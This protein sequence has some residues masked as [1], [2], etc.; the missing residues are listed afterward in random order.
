ML[1]TRANEIAE[2]ATAW[3]LTGFADVMRCEV[4]SYADRS[5][6]RLLMGAE[7]ISLEVLTDHQQAL[8]RAETLRCRLLQRGW[9]KRQ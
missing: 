8:R 9:I 7:P 2:T 1:N 3:V 6:V 4:S 5:V